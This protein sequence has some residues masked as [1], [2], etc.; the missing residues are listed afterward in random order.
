MCFRGE[1]HQVLLNLIVNAAQAIADAVKSPDEKGV[2]RVTTSRKGDYIEIQVSDSGIGICED[3]RSKIFEPFF[4]TRDV[5]QGV[6]QGLAMAHS[7]IV[8]RHG[9][10]IYFETEIGK[11]TTFVVLLPVEAQ[12]MTSENDEPSLAVRQA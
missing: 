9:G 11:G 8:Q 10:K 2:I 5:G 7:I 3:H 4:T 1:L 6:G 12:T